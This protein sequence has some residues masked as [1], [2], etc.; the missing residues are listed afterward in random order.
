MKR[1]L[2]TAN[3]VREALGPDKVLLTRERTGV[4]RNIVGEAVPKDVPNISYDECPRR[5]SGH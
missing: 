2:L 3:R 1:P 4:V 5:P